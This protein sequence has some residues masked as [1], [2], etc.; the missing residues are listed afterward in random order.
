MFTLDAM[1]SNYSVPMFSLDT[2]TLLDSYNGQRKGRQSCG[3]TL[4]AELDCVSESQESF[5]RVSLCHTL[6]ARERKAGKTG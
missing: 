5:G 3:R 6:E 1:K 4:E 2:V